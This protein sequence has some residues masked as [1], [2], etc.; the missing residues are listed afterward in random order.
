MNVPNQNIIPLDLNRLDADILS[1]DEKISSL[2]AQRA[3]LVMVRN[4]ITKLSPIKEQPTFS[5]PSSDVGISEFILTL[6]EQG[7]LDTVQIAMEY[8]K[9]VGKNSEDV[10]NNVSN[11]LS[12]LKDKDLIRR[13]PKGQG[14]KEGSI[15]EL[16]KKE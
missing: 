8:G 12:R 10:R 15:W 13:I 5:F 7:K 2:Q 1:I 11:A 16:I 6:L 9:S 3:E 4:Y 14:R